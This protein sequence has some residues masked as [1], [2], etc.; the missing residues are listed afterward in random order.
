V[1]VSNIADIILAADAAW[2]SPQ[3]YMVLDKAPTLTN[4]RDCNSLGSISS[5]VFFFPI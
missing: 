1:Q 2:L 3:A 4:F 5:Y